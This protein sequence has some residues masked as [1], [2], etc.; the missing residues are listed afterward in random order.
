M[1]AIVKGFK[2][3]GE[4]E[5]SYIVEDIINV[6]YTNEKITLVKS[7]GTTEGYS[8]AISDGY[9]YAISIYVEDKE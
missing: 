1:K 2:S 3:N 6:V 9:K 4:E 7:D 5:F 8:N